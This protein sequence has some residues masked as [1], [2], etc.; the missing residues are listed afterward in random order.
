MDGKSY[1]TERDCWFMMNLIG[2]LGAW[3]NH[4]KQ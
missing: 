1:H 4:W 3:T 2:D